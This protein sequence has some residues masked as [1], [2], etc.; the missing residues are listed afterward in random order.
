MKRLPPP[1][2]PFTIAAMSSQ[3]TNEIFYF[4]FGSNMLSSVFFGGFRGFKRR[5]AERAVLRG[6][7][8]AFTEPGIP[9]FEPAFANLQKECG[10]VCEGVLYRVT[11]DELDVLDLTEG[12]RAYDIIDVEVNAEVSGTVPAKAF[13][14]RVSVQGLKPTKRYLELLIAGAEERGLSEQWLR[15]LKSTPYVDRSNMPDMVPVIAKT[16]AWFVRHGFPD[17]L[18]VIKKFRYGTG[19]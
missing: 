7:R 17:P 5:A 19:P 10:A 16:S 4:A 8:L 18:K 3:G 1:T 13:K 2:A 15:M 12:G 6:Y 9:F 11:A 14:S